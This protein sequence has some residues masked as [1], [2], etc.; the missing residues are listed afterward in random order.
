MF[1]SKLTFTKY[2]FKNAFRVS[3]SLDPDQERHPVVSDL[4]PI[5]LQR[6][7]ADDKIAA[8]KERVN[9]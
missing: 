3:N 5:C 9:F 7:S 2:P 1:S 8:D 4:G 6:L